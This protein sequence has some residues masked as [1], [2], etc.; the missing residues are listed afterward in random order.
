MALA[1]FVSLHVTHLHVI[2][3]FV[4]SFSLS[5]SLRCIQDKDIIVQVSDIMSIEYTPTEL[6]EDCLYLNVYTPSAAVKGDKLPVSQ[7][8]PYNI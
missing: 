5:V 8:S 4:C 7:Q 1:K 6:S 2:C 3:V